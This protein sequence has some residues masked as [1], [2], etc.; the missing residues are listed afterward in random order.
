MKAIL[1][2][3]RTIPGL[4]GLFG[5][6]LLA[7]LIWFFA[8]ALLGIS[9]W[10]VVLLLALIP[11]LVWLVVVVVL[12]RRAQK[13]DAALVAGATEVDERAAKANAQAVAAKE[14]ESAVASRLSEALRTLKT[15]GS[16]KGGFLYERPWY[17]IIG[18]PG[19]GKT[20]AIRNSGLTFP[21]AEGRVSGVGGTRNCDWWIAEQAVLIDT[22]GRYTTQDSDAQVDKAGWNRFLD[23]LR[24]ERAEQPLNGV[25]VA[26]G[27]DMLCKLDASSRQQHARAVRQRVRELEERLG[28]RLPVY[29][30]VSKCDLLSGF[31]EFFDNLDAEGRRQVWGVSF[32]ASTTPE[33]ASGNFRGEFKALL[34]RLQDRVLERLQAE[35]GAEQRAA[36]AG[37]GGQFAS[38]EEPVDAFIQAAFG[39]SKL[40]A[41]PYLRGVY[42]TSGT[43][44]GTPIDRLT[45]AMS[46]TFGLDARRA[47]QLSAPKGRSY[48]LGR[49]LLDVVFNEATL[50]VRDKGS[51]KRRR[52]AM[53]GVVAASAL[54]LVAGAAW[55]WLAASR[56]G[57]RAERVATAVGAAEQAAQ[58]VSKTQPLD[59]VGASADLLAV[60]PYLDSTQGRACPVTPR[61]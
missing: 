21:L 44:E 17:V 49:L 23:L 31:T 39:G 7:A 38:L 36:I 11:P 30:L 48:F 41:A 59:R 56:E 24:R 58:A 16:G 28:Q 52:L 4:A 60:L 34:Q 43:Q 3:L 55:A 50:A 22:A 33:G 45:G 6:L 1:S 8:P 14:E 42:F 26:F 35:R 51:E 19:S 47:A 9:T 29:V 46:R 27:A 53:A 10:W 25:V 37:F 5:S 2:T 13:R 54:L 12:A 18:P 40:D 61:P 32:E 57:A 15:A 20:T